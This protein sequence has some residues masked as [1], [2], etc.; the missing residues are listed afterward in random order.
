MIALYIAVATVAGVLL[1]VGFM[2]N[3]RAGRTQSGGGGDSGL[4]N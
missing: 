1:L 4:G 3:K 2:R